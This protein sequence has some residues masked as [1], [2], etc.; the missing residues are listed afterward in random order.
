MN[1]EPVMIRNGAA[2]LLII[3]MLS[4]CGHTPQ[5][6]AA[7]GALIGAAA[8]A[9]IGLASQPRYRDDDHSDR[10][11]REKR[12]HRYYEERRHRRHHRHDHDDWGR[13]RDDDWEYY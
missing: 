10:Y 2:S 13:H 7:S 8:G 5:E 11:Y 12:H 6:R 3:G 4:A 1:G 9:A